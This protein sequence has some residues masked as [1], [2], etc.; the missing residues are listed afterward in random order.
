M[1]SFAAYLYIHIYCELGQVMDEK[2]FSFSGSLI[3]TTISDLKFEFK[4]LKGD[5]PKRC[6]ARNLPSKLR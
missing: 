6:Q 4:V 5:F 3:S 1:H 2:D